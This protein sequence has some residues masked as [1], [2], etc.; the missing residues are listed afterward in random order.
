MQRGLSTQINRRLSAL[1]EKIPTEISI[2]DIMGLDYSLYDSP[3]IT[4][5]YVTT[6][7]RGTIDCSRNINLQ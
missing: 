1:N 4:D 2:K 5:T 7:H 3:L 6:S